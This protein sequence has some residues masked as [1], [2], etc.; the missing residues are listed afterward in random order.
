MSCCGD[1]ASDGLINGCIPVASGVQ[2]IKCGPLKVGSDGRL[3]AKDDATMALLMPEV[4]STSAKVLVAEGACFGEAGPC[5]GMPPKDKSASH[6]GQT[7]SPLSGNLQN[8]PFWTSANGRYDFVATCAEVLL[9]NWYIYGFASTP[10][11]MAGTILELNLQDN[12]VN[13]WTENPTWPGTVAG[14]PSVTPFYFPG[15][16]RAILGAGSHSIKFAIRRVG[17]SG[18]NTTIYVKALFDRRLQ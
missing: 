15:T 11:A 14:L 1:I 7:Y 9:V 8:M 13:V 12:G 16:S 18:T 4:N 6:I 10:D 3:C 5:V 2:R 17:G